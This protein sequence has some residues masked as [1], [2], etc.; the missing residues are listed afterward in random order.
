[1]LCLVP[2]A[3]D[4]RGRR[5]G[6]H[7]A[8]IRRKWAAY[9]RRARS[10]RPRLPEECRQLILRLAKENPAWGYVRIRGELLKLG[11]GASPTAIRNLLRRHG[12]PVS[13][14]RSRLSWRQF[15]RAQA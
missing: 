6:W 9:G 10:G 11:Y 4:D 3:R 7:R 12:I 5:T 8:L 2:P 1:M 13:P 15:L 14:H